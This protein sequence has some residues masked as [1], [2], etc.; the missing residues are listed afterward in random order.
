MTHFRGENRAEFVAK[1]FSRIS[2][3]YDLLNTI[4]TAGRHHAWRR[5]T[6]DLA[7]RG[8]SGPALDVASGTGDLAIELANRGAVTNVI[9]TDFSREM[10]VC[11]SLK[12]RRR[13]LSDRIQ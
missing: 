8:I 1:M 10:L 12:I 9:A 2:Q 5:M 11:A 4:M 7:E 6:A 3:R 13:G